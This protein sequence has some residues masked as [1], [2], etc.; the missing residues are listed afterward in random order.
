M[1]VQVEL[2]WWSGLVEDD[3]PGP[4]EPDYEL[5]DADTGQ[6]LTDRQLVTYEEVEAYIAAHYPGCE[7]WMPPPA[8][9]EQTAALKRVFGI[10]ESGVELDH[11]VIRRFLIGQLYQFSYPDE[12]TS[13]IRASLA[14]V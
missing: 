11:I 6:S 9:P 12:I 1:R 10:L 5:F 8:S 4:P 7:R 2:T 13:L 3:A 14:R